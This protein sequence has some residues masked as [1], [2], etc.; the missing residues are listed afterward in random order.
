MR[1]KLRDCRGET[2]AEVFASILIAALSV[3]ML[4]GGIMT[5]V[6]VDGAA[7]ELDAD[8]FQALSAAESQTGAAEQ[9]FAV[10]IQGGAGGSRAVAVELYG[11]GGLYSYRE[12][13]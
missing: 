2:L 5:A 8:Y 3:A 1:K 12:A 13:P 9:G 6:R 11:G 10:R 4:F 7:R